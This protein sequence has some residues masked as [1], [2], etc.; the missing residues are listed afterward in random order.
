MREFKKGQ[1]Y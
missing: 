1:K